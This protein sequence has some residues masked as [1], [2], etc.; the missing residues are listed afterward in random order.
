[1]QY[2]LQALTADVTPIEKTMTRRQ[3][4]ES[5]SPLWVKGINAYFIKV[6]RQFIERTKQ[7]GAYKAVLEQFDE[8]ATPET[9]HTVSRQI[10]I[11]Y[12]FSHY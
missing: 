5:G 6:I 12:H 8:I 10:E 7:H 2:Q 11:K 1:M 9:F 3:L 4:F